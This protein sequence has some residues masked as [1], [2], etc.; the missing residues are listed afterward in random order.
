MHHLDNNIN[1]H[2]AQRG[3]NHNII[4]NPLLSFAEATVH[5]RPAADLIT[6]CASSFSPCASTSTAISVHNHNIANQI[7]R[8]D[9]GQEIIE[10]GEADEPIYPLRFIRNNTSLTEAKPPSFYR[11]ES[12]Q[13]SEEI[14]N[15]SHYNNLYTPHISYV[16][17]NNSA[18]E[19]T[20]DHTADIYITQTNIENCEEGFASSTIQSNGAHYIVQ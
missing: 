3:A 11:D 17:S 14:A 9:I 19:R 1:I 10:N 5:I 13:Y 12:M 20:D 16:E 4:T 2:H 7:Q 18:D 6:S 15:V 8:I